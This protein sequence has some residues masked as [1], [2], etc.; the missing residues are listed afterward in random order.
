[1]RPWYVPRN[2]HFP[3]LLSSRSISSTRRMLADGIGP[4]TRS[5]ASL[6]FPLAWLASIGALKA[7]DVGNGK[8]KCPQACPVHAFACMEYRYRY[9]WNVGCGC[10]CGCE[11][12]YTEGYETSVLVHWQTGVESCRSIR[13]SST[14][15]QCQPLVLVLVR[16]SDPNLS[17]SRRIR[18]HAFH[19]A[20]PSTHLA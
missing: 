6:F 11:C 17:S 4:S 7:E 15:Y 19:S 18:A 3:R 16:L 10:E 9:H 12:G 2:T 13:P 14:E 20:R 1:M 5:E 8:R